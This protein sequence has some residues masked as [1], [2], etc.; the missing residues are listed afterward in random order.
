MLLLA[1][2]VVVLIVVKWGQRE[3]DF[4]RTQSLLHDASLAL[5]APDGDAA[6]LASLSRAQR[7]LTTFVQPSVVHVDGI[8]KR[9][10]GLDAHS[11]GSGWI[12]DDE[13]H[14]VTAWHVV[15]HLDD[16]DIELHNG[17][18]RRA[19]F[20]AGDSLTDIAVLKIDPTHTI[21]ATRARHNSV[22]Q[23][24]I[25]F[26]FGSPLDFRFSV[27]SGVVSGI[28]REI[29][30]AIWPGG[31]RYENSI[32]LDAPINP[33]SSGGPVTNHLGKVVGM[34]TAIAADPRDRGPERFSGVAMAIPIG[35]VNAVVPQL[36]QTG[37]VARGYIGVHALDQDQ[38]LRALAGD[39]IPADAKV[40]V[41][42][43]AHEL[44]IGDVVYQDDG[45]WMAAN[46]L[47]SD[48]TEA[49]ALEDSDLRRAELIKLTE[50]IHRLLDVLHAPKR[51][52]LIA[53]VIP[54]EAAYKAGIRRGDLVT[55]IQDQSVDSVGQLRAA[56]SSVLPETDA[57]LTFW[58]WRSGDV[59]KD[60]QTT[61]IRMGRRPRER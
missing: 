2:A 26:A 32:Q 29:G 27:T 54:E 1:A 45:H 14:I 46:L 37:V 19:E 55:A 35:T 42:G 44:H 53:H 43:S 24:D 9:P 60:L 11:T 34:S 56:V 28:G 17:S 49:R 10:N 61:N 59:D 36:L 50:P 39:R 41:G 58:R 15:R 47:S 13:G 21:P 30:P 23:G 31:P 20:V 3:L 51:G 12:W 33:G 38:P 52:V 8:R 5:H 25:V 6:V 57:E 7:L 16:I 22:Q 4:Q 48:V 40:V 18:I